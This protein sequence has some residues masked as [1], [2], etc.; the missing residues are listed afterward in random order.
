MGEW[1]SYLACSAWRC[2][3]LTSSD[4]GVWLFYLEVWLS[5]AWRCGA[6][7]PGD[8]ATAVSMDLATSQSENRPCT[9]EFSG[10]DHSRSMKTAVYLTS[11]CSG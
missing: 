7:L 6:I 2:G 5:S 4:I 3:Y 9:K 8:M 10:K 11:Q 1:L